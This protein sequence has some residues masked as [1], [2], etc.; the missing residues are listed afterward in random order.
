MAA[1][2]RGHT[3]RASVLLTCLLLAT[4]AA[5]SACDNTDKPVVVPQQDMGEPDALIDRDV[6][7]EDL[8]EDEPDMAQP[9]AVEDQ[10]DEPDAE[11]DADDCSCEEGEVCVSNET[12]TDR[13]Y[14]RDCLQEQC[15][16]GEICDNDQCV[17]TSC[18]GLDCGG[19]PNVC[20]G[21]Q[22][23]VGSCSDPDVACPDGLECI[24]D[25]C[26]QPCQVQPDCGNLA[27]IDNY[28]GACEESRDCGSGRICLAEQCV[29]PCTQE[30]SRCRQDEVCQP[31]TGLCVEPCQGD[32]D[33][34]AQEVCD[35]VTSLCEDRECSREGERGECGADQL[36]LNGRCQY[37][38][39]V[40][41]GGLCSG[42]GVGSSG[43]YRMIGIAAPV[44]VLDSISVSESYRLQS[45]GLRILQER[46]R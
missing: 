28:C 40:F 43:Q 35:Q 17:A 7:G 36:C 38:S 46:E 8:G 30:P 21:G 44:P 34:G 3:G 15:D 4:L 11:P 39:P 13:C 31:S 19:Y 26:R 22:C 16:A 45:G 32:S 5:L 10:G 1:Y 2:A 24:E 42:C 27:C 20:R 33:C 25:E 6:S 37:A 23:V 9:D 41:F 29:L 12:V 18:A 14:P